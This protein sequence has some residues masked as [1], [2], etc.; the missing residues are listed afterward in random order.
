[1]KLST[2]AALAVCCLTAAACSS[3]YG[4]H[5]AIKIQAG[6]LNFNASTGVTAGYLGGT[7]DRNANVDKNG[8]AIIVHPCQ[9]DTPSTYANMNSKA[10][11][12]ASSV[13]GA[14]SG[15]AGLA[16][17]ASGGV[18][19][20]QIAWASGD[21]TANG[22]PALIAQAAVTGHAADVIAALCGNSQLPSAPAGSI[23]R[24]GVSPPNATK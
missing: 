6:G 20:P 18:V 10:Q 7:I 16:A 2:L 9:G 24:D 4:Y 5:D 11:A 13:G 19:A 12:N 15:V 1:M 22:T 14:P 3:G 23:V 8:Q 21:E 17:A